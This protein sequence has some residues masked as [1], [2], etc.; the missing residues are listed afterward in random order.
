MVEF[1]LVQF[2]MV[3]YRNQEVVIVGAGDSACEERTIFLNY[4]KKVT[5][6]VRSEKFRASKIIKNVFVKPKTLLF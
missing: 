6:L 4:V 3:F 1:R 5:M 2:A